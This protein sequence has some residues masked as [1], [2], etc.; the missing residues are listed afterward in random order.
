MDF[1]S[2][3]KATYTL[4]VFICVAHLS[5]Q[6]VPQPRIS[7]HTHTCTGTHTGTRTPQLSLATTPL[8]GESLGR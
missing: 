5:T 2:F 1:P 8:Y 6:S 3:G 4:F 7:V